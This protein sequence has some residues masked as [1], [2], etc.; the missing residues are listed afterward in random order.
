M[1]KKSLK[2]LPE[3]LR[4]IKMAR[5]GSWLYSLWEMSFKG[6]LR[7]S[8]NGLYNYILAQTLRSPLRIA[9]EKK[10]TSFTT[11]NIPVITLPGQHSDEL[12][13]M[14]LRAFP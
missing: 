8:R 1:L 2:H 4:T 6:F 9:F 7:E 3:A 12:K 10:N 5:N 13:N 14:I 11:Y